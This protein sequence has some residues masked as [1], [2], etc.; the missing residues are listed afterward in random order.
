MPLVDPNGGTGQRQRDFH[1]EK[2]LFKGLLNHVA[3]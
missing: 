2:R 1:E 3:I